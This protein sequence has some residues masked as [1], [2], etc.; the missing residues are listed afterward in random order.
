MKKTQ[1]FVSGVPGCGKSTFGRWLAQQKGF[2]HVDMERDGLDQ[3][4]FRQAWN[5]FCGGG[6]AQSFLSA[7]AAHPSSVILD[8]GFP[9]HCIQLVQRL[10]DAGLKV[11]WFEADRLASR[12][13]FVRRGTVPADRF[14]SQY[15]AISAHR[16]EIS[17][18]FGGN[19]IETLRADGTRLPDEDIFARM[20]SRQA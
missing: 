18:L 10:K 12:D 4:G 19:I 9:L 15:A 17:S 5:K 13:H 7:V 3:H 8:W 16:A 11:F 14:D 2:V 6:E 1:L 20:F